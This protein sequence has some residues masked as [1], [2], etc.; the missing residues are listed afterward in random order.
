MAAPAPEEP[1]EPTTLRQAVAG[2]IFAALVLGAL[3]AAAVV[4]EA[5][6][7]EGDG[8]G[9]EVIDDHSD[10]AETGSATSTDET[11]E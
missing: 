4:S 6:D 7:G 10:D 3:A 1:K 11:H 5:N 9:S 8:H 2:L